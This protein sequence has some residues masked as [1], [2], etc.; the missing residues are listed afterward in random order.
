MNRRVTITFDNGPTPGVTESVLDELGARDLR[1]TFFV[2][3]RDLRLPGLRG[4]AR[5]AFEEGHW[6][7]NHTLTHSVQFGESE[8][9]DFG[10]RE[11]LGA[12]AELGDLAHPDR[13]FR[14]YG[15]GGIISPRV[16]TQDAIRTLEDGAFTCVLWNCVPRDWEQPVTWVRNALETIESQPWSLVVLHDQDT[17]AMRHLGEFLDELGARGIE[18]RQDFPADC[19]PIRRGRVVGSLD[20][21]Y[22]APAA[23]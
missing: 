14:P 13:L 9:P 10:R 22:A 20:H 17:G 4:I 11:I 21:L 16:L 1:V 2:V 15:G 7:G 6:I 18:V 23:T 3:G 12:Q 5:R 19:V 8:D